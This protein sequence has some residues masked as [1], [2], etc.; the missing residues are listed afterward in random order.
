MDFCARSRDNFSRRIRS[1]KR[2]GMVEMDESEAH[3]DSLSEK[4]CV[5]VHW[6][7]RGMLRAHERRW[8]PNRGSSNFQGYSKLLEALRLLRFNDCGELSLNSRKDSKLTPW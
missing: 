3:N 2:R 4:F 7:W 8:R 1:G 5:F 6:Q